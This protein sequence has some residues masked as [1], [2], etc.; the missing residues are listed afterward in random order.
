M[1]WAGL[2]AIVSKTHLFALVC[3]DE[4]DRVPF[5]GHKNIFT[6]DGFAKRVSTVDVA[7]SHGGLG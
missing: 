5:A 6:L 2:R 3:P 7:N 1:T 4:V